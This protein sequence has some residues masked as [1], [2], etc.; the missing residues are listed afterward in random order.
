MYG[1]KFF[2]GLYESDFGISGLIFTRKLGNLLFFHPPWVRQFFQPSIAEHCFREFEILETKN[3]KIHKIRE[4]QHLE[5]RTKTRKA[6]N[7]ALLLIW[8]NAL[9]EKHQIM[10][11]LLV[12]RV[13]II[14]QIS[15]AMK[16]FAHIKT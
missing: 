13:C 9:S 7:I 8:R 2:S 14:R 5:E 16:C 12:V 10:T 1:F 15:Y 11:K 4:N 6:K 3:H